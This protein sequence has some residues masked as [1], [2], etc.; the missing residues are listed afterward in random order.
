[1]FI[2]VVQVLYFIGYTSANE[3]AL[4]RGF[5]A[6]FE[7]TKEPQTLQLYADFVP[8]VMHESGFWRFEIDDI[9]TADLSSVVASSDLEY[10]P[11]IAIHAQPIVDEIK[12]EHP[13]SRHNLLPA[14][15]TALTDSQL[16]Q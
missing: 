10:L 1:M 14:K 16:S 2:S 8:S 13:P 11:P 12:G 7:K 15:L 4:C 9:V 3:D 6:T 5:A